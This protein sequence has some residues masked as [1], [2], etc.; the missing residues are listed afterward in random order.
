MR[1]I[2]EMEDADIV[3]DLR[4]LNSGKRSQYD[5]F[6]SECQK[7]LEEDIGSAVDDRR[8]GTVTHLARGISVHDLRDQVQA[9]CPDGTP[10]PSEAWMRVQF[11][12]KTRHAR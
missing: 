4:H 3:P 2:L 6:R 5:V 12:P 8:H 10:M 1:M 11:W 7:F 9:R